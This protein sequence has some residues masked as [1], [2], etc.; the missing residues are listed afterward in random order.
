MK[1]ISCNIAHRP[2][3]W[4]LLVKS[5]ADIAMLREGEALPEA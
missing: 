2:D 1:T 4:H 5:D 3:V